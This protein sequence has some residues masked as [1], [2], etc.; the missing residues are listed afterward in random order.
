MISFRRNEIALGAVVQSLATLDLAEGLRSYYIQSDVRGFKQSFYQASQLMV[1]TVGQTDGSLFDTVFPFTCA[2]LSDNE[3]VIQ[4]MANVATISLEKT[5]GNPLRVQYVTHML[6]LA[7]LE[8]DDQL[9]THIEE[10]AS[11]GRVADRRAAVKGKDFYS[12]LLKRDEEGLRQLIQKHSRLN[13]D[14]ALFEDFMSL[15]AIYEAKLCW[16]RGMKIQIDSPLV[17]MELIPVEPLRH[18]EDVYKFLEPDWT[19]PRQG[20]L[21]KVGRLFKGH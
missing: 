2:L 14:R 5:A 16:R 9:R 6:Q 21:G 1:S 17:P 3:R 19:P 12:L 18:Y 20:L 11:H 8:D 4:S 7:I 13:G 15:K 10:M